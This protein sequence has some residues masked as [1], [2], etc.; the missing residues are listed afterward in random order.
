QTVAILHGGGCLF[1]R[2]V[3]VDLHHATPLRPA[4][5]PRAKFLTELTAWAIASSCSSTELVIL[6]RRTGFDALI[7]SARA[8]MPCHQV[9][10]PPPAPSATPCRG[11]H[12][13]SRRG[14]PARC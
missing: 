6:G 9:F 14:G 7:S 3:D 8:L 5:S 12:R 2:R 10:T 1:D 11:S 13:A 4:R